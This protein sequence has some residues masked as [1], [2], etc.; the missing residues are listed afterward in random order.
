MDFQL[1]F[2]SLGTFC[3]TLVAIGGVA[4][5]MLRAELRAITEGEDLRR[6]QLEKDAVKRDTLVDAKFDAIQ[7]TMLGFAATLKGETD[8][9][10]HLDR[11]HG[12]TVSKL[13]L[14]TNR[15][16]KVEIITDN[17]EK[18]LLR[19]ELTMKDNAETANNQFKQLFQLISE[20]SRK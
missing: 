15:I 16:T 4:R 2:I 19:V 14:V 7:N 1:I 9:R 13:D 20:N 12:D 18:T 8:E 6:Q 3:G 5:W 17:I 10:H 11:R